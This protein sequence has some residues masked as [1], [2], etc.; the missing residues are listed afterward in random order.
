MQKADV[1][2]QAR[3]FGS[4]LSNK[5]STTSTSLIK[6]M[7]VQQVWVWVTVLTMA[8]PSRRP[9]TVRGSTFKI[10]SSINNL[11][12]TI[13]PVIHTKCN[14]CHY[15]VDACG[16]FSEKTIFACGFRNSWKTYFSGFLLLFCF[17]SCFDKICFCL[18]AR[19][20]KCKHLIS[21]IGAS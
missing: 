13:D 2:K 18:H 21:G 1:R 5:I 20:E 3:I 17:A 14:W 19:L 11:L 10:L 7:Q 8:V 4:R 16:E 15:R 6:I 12:S 9:L